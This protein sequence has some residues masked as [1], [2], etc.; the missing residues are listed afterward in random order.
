MKKPSLQKQVNEYKQWCKV[1]QLEFDNMKE[2]VKEIEKENKLTREFLHFAKTI[3][4][5]L[6]KQSKIYSQSSSYEEYTDL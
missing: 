1:G 3:A 5:N 2:R 6:S 4:L